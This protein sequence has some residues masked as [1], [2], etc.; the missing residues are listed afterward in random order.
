[1]CIW[2]L[3]FFQSF[4][5]CYFFCTFFLLGNFYSG[6]APHANYG[7]HCLTHHFQHCA[8]CVYE[9]YSIFKVFEKAVCFPHF[10][11]FRNLNSADSHHANYGKHRLNNHFP[12]CAHCGYDIYSI[13][14]VFEM[15]VCFAHFGLF[16]IWTALILTIPTIVNVFQFIISSIAH[17]VYMRLTVFSKF[18]KLLFLLH[19]FPF[20]KFLVRWY[21]TC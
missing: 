19:I 13:C 12:H 10:C 6:D 7:K 5:N 20:R 8:H 18:S 9:I 1:M 4:P 21:A 16:E 14:K 2:D 3:Q 15:A 11:F 17:S